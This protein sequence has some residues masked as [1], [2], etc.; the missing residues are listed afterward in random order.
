MKVLVGI[1]RVVDH[2][3]HVRAKA[4]G[5]GADIA[6]VKMSINPF[7]E[8]AVEEAVRLKEAGVATE[9]VVVTV[10]DSHF[11]DVLRHSL[12][13]GADRA[14]LVDSPNALNNL[15]YAKVLREVVRREE[16]QLILLGKQAIDDD[17]A[18]VGQMLAALLNIGQGT[19]AS[20]VTV[21]NGKVTVVR[22]IDAGQE[23]IELNL[24][25]VITADLRLND[26][27]YIKLPNLMMAKKKPLET[28][29]LADLGVATS[30]KVSTTHVNEP[31]VRAP[32]KK[33]N[34]VQELI[35]VLRNQAKVI[36]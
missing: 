7:D 14:I 36:Q 20:T 17:A 27:R 24:P 13:L 4:D 23:T 19:F 22:E 1:K 28:I 33:V 5:S 6:S 16:P 26:P 9:V 21:A 8:H 34:S 25:A 31:P 11:Q 32:G 29:A 3:V 10:G 2:N 12:A 30:S 35:E 15:A 18:E